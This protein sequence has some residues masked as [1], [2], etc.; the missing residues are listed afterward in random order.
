M[1]S[2]ASIS[3]IWENEETLEHFEHTVELYKELFRIEPEVIA[4]DLHPEYLPS[5]Y[6][7]A[8]PRNRICRW[9][10][11]STPCP[12]CQL[13]GENRVETPVIGVA[14]DGVGY[15][16]DGAIWVENF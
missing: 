9:C 5:K 12:Y 16:T 14:F 15:G 2:S 3:A 8:L 4:C 10:R 13:H 1:P 11:C 7:A 6:A